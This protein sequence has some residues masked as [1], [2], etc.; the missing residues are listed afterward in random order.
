MY[1]ASQFAIN[2]MYYIRL[3][4]YVFAFTYFKSIAIFATGMNLY[5]EM[6][7]VVA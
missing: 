7:S 3:T 2:N 4:A 6:Y 1:Q 5:M